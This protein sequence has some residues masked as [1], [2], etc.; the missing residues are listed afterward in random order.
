MRVTPADGPNGDVH[1]GP[2]GGTSYLIQPEELLEL[3]RYQLAMPTNR[4]FKRAMI[5]PKN[6]WH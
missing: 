6:E 2:D 1:H 5:F 4:V 3:I